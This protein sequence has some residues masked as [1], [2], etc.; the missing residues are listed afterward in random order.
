[1]A[2]VTVKPAD[3]TA[4]LDRFDG[5]SMT[6]TATVYGITVDLTTGANDYTPPVDG[7]AVFDTA[8]FDTDI[9]S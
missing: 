7:A 4:T 6:F 9:Y 3:Q 2:T 1:M 5:G 8:V